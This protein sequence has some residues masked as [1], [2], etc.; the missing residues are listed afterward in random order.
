MSLE[1]RRAAACLLL[2]GVSVLLGGCGVSRA[3]V[4]GRYDLFSPIPHAGRVFLA[5]KSD[6]TYEE[7]VV[8]GKTTDRYSGRWRFQGGSVYFDVLWI[9]A[10]FAPQSIIEADR[11]ASPGQ[12]RFTRPGPNELPAERLFG[13]ITLDVFSDWSVEFRKKAGAKN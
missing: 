3:D 10:E 1:L 4:V 2:C 8:S 9:P 11:N 7:T 13:W 5:V 6:G 12:G